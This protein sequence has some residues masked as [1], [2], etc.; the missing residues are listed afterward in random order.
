MRALKASELLRIWDEGQTCSAADRAL[1]LLATIGVTADPR[2][3]AT[4]TIG[5]RDAYLL[6]LRQYTFGDVM[7]ARTLCPHCKG[8]LEFALPVS[9]L[10]AA[11]AMPGP[12]C[13]HDLDFEEWHLR[14]RLPNTEDLFYIAGV[15]DV[16]AQREEL[17]ARCITDVRRGEK[18]TGIWEMTNEVIRLVV[19]K[20]ENLDP[21]A[22]INLK[23]SCP[24]CGADWDALFDILGYLDREI[25]MYARRLLRE[26]DVLARAYGWCEADILALSS[27]RRNAY[28]GM[29]GV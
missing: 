19:D 18:E 14:F 9:Q 2:Q 26:V 16:N 1:Q 8:P 10:L 22:E 4:L 17:L 13:W 23:L 20:M 27:R 28:I 25:S 24:E 15:G 21:Y 3:L 7:Q 11:H 6:Q 5:Q 12:P 29:C